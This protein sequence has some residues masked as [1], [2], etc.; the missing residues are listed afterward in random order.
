MI[1]WFLSFWLPL[2][3]FILAY[4]AGIYT[5]KF[6]IKLRLKQTDRY[7]CLLG[8]SIQPATFVD[9]R[10][11]KY[12]L[13]AVVREACERFGMTTDEWNSFTVTCEKTQESAIQDVVDDLGLV[14]AEDNLLLVKYIL[15]G[16]TKRGVG[17]PFSY[18]QIK[19]LV[20]PVADSAPQN[21]SCTWQTKNGGAGI[22]HPGKSLGLV[23]GIK[24]SMI[25]TSNA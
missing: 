9:P 5:R 3:G 13:G 7:K 21:P 14:D 25:D 22:L 16:E 20:Y 18:E 17:G 24:I 6:W 11:R 1:E 8:S 10:G 4:T 15:N 12:S 19:A 2:I 23:D